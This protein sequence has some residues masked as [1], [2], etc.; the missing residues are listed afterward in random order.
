MQLHLPQDEG[1]HSNANGSRVAG[2]DHQSVIE[3]LEDVA[4]SDVSMRKRMDRLCFPPGSNSK[5]SGCMQVFYPNAPA[6]GRLQPI[7]AAPHYLARGRARRCL[8]AKGDVHTCLQKLGHGQYVPCPESLRLLQ[9]SPDPAALGCKRAST[10]LYRSF[11]AS[12]CG[13]HA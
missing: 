8:Q 13:A 2:P 5:C 3:G 4:E 1:W 10:H 7:S 6:Q 12:A 9:S 11:D